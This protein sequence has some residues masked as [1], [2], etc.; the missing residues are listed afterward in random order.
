MTDAEREWLSTL[1]FMTGSSAGGADDPA[2]CEDVVGDMDAALS[3][4]TGDRST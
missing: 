1:R 2:L 3:I 4:L